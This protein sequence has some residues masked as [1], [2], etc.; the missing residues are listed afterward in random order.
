MK[1]D[2]KRNFWRG[3][4]TELNPKNF[5]SLH[6]WLFFTVAWPIMLEGLE[7]VAMILTPIYPVPLLRDM[8]WTWWNPYPTFCP[9]LSAATTDFS[10]DYCYGTNVGH[11]GGPYS[12]L[13]YWLMYALAFGGRYYPAVNDLT[14]F[15]V[16]NFFF[17]WRIRRKFPGY[18]KMALINTLYSWTAW[19]FLLAWPQILLTLYMTAGSLIVKNRW[20]R[21]TL[22]IL[23]PALRFPLGGPAY[24]WTFILRFSFHTPGNAPP[25]AATAIFWLVALGLFIRDWKA[26]RRV[27]V[28]PEAIIPVH[29]MPASQSNLSQL[30]RPRASY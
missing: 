1:T 16:I 2:W 18:G 9:G 15:V 27:S 4:R 29:T 23:G 22:L 26:T 6:D 20:V 8:K 7:V 12:L 28:V 30:L 5:F 17:V 21:L 11:F 24:L 3:W 13:W 14:V 10:R 25:Y 19:M